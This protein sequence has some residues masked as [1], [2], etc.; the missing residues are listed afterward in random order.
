M[1]RQ[2]AASGLGGALNIV[3]L[4]HRPPQQ[5]AIVMPRQLSK[6]PLCA[7]QDRSLQK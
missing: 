4:G 7:I 3:S 5:N 1:K 2:I 6:R